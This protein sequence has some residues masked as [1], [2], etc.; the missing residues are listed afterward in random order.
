MGSM[1]ENYCTKCLGCQAVN[2][3]ATIPPVKTK[4]MP[5][6]PWRDLAV[7]LMGPIPTGESL[8]VTV[9]YYS[10]WIEVDALRSTTSSVIIRSDNGQWVKPSKP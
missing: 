2:S 1:A 9:D 10:R 3:A 6:N 7:D 8:L 5:T 4:V